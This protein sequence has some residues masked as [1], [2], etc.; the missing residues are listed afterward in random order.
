MLRFVSFTGSL[1]FCFIVI[2]LFGG[3]Y[4]L[5]VLLSLLQAG[6]ILLDT[7]GVVKLADFGVSACLFDAAD[8]QRSRNTFVG[9]PCW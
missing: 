8:R 5:I 3:S 1:P 9:T 2:S 6:N 4:F 7:N